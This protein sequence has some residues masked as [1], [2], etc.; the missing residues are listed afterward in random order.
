[1]LNPTGYSQVLEELVSNYSPDDA[2]VGRK[3]NE[4][5]YN[6]QIGLRDST[7]G[8]PI[9]QPKSSDIC[10]HPLFFPA[11]KLLCCGWRWSPT[12]GR[13]VGCMFRELEVQPTESGL[14]QIFSIR[15]HKIHFFTSIA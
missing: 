10:T 8:E 14:Q 13:A 3:G 4:Y 5:I 1:M 2:N 15:S 9:E 7:F 11:G 6:P 12:I